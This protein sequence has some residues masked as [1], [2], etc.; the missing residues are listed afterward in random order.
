[1]NTQSDTPRTDAQHKWVKMDKS[2]MAFAR[3]LERELNAANERIKR[4]E[5]AANK[6]QAAIANGE[7]LDEACREWIKAKESKP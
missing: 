7:G 4:L 2:T 1:M 5:E 6:M 3:T